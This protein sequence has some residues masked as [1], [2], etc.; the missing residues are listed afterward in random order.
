MS[1][2]SSWSGRDTLTALIVILIWGVNFAPMKFGLETM[3]PLELGVGRYFFATFP[4]IFFIRF[5]QIRVRWVVLLAFFQCVGQFC[6][7][8][9]SMAAGMPAALASV[10]LQTQVFFTVLWSFL[11]YKQTPNKLLWASMASAVVGLLFFGINALQNNGAHTVTM[12]SLILILSAAL[13]WGAS[14]IITRQAQNEN[15][16]YNPLALI[17]WSSLIAM[18]VYIVLVSILV[19]DSAR[20]LTIQA[21]TQINAKTWGS[22]AFLGWA[23][24]LIGYALWTA[25]LKRHH[26]NKVAPFSL[27]VPVI[28]LIVGVVW[29]DETI[30]IWQW[31]GAACVG[32]S[33]VLVVFGPR[34]FK[35]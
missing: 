6:F 18:L 15:P 4:L 25:L 8:F 29:L 13:L 27:G 3:T 9:Y 14:N 7:L 1:T 34:W 20:W 16:H 33:L 2:T 11:I 10:L 24:S 23:S 35:H 5:P 26:A 19:P 30:N 31:C 17:V 12:L 28:G 22:I 32:F 21:W